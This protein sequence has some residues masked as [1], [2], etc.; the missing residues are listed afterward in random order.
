M[1]L[2]AFVVKIEGAV[3]E[4][5]PRVVELQDDQRGA[6]DVEALLDVPEVNVVALG[7][8]P[9]VSGRYGVVD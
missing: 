5:R 4:G 8:K 3:V 9:V 1:N 2:R 7:V 6:R